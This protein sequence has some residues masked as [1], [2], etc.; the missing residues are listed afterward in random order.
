MAA[1]PPP[2]PRLPPAP[3]TPVNLSNPVH[4]QAYHSFEAEREVNTWEYGTEYKPLPAKGLV[5]YDG[6]V[7]TQPFRP[8]APRPMPA[9]PLKS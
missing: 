3:P 5:F 1:T 2:M 9:P 7:W 6:R 4:A 8:S